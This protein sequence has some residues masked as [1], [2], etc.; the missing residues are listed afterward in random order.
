MSTIGKAG[1]LLD[2]FSAATPEWGVSEAAASLGIPR[3]TAHFLLTSLTETGLLE[4]RR[5]GRYVLGWRVFE[6]GEVQR[7]STALAPA[8]RPVMEAF[9]RRFSQT[10]CLGVFLR[11]SVLFIHKVVG[12]TPLSVLGPRVGARYE[13]HGFASGRALLAALPRQTAEG[14]LR[15]RE[16]R[17]PTGNSRVDPDE[18]LRE[19]ETI[20]R[21][22]V[23]FDHGEAVP[24]VGCVATG[25]RG[26][27]GDVVA[28]LSLSA[29]LRRFSRREREF[30]AAV[31]GAAAKVTERL[32]S[33]DWPA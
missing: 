26:P 27:Q 31:H 20:R 29:P 33:S 16:L 22:G 6:L 1:R 9:V 2:L 4:V 15:G 10:V 23:A 28:S 25:I 13:A 19:L 18:L 14:R 24:D 21:A 12:D 11:E 32:C 3:S 17:T 7:S 5:R 8:A 30:A